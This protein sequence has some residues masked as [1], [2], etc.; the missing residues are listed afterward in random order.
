[1]IIFTNLLLIAGFLFLG[2]RHFRLLPTKKFFWPA[3][4]LK[5]SMGVLVGLLYQYYYQGGDT[6]AF[7]DSAIALKNS[8]LSS[9]VNFADIFLRNNYESLPGFQYAWIPSAF[10]VK[11]LSFFAWLTGDNY[12]LTGLYFSVFSFF[13]LWTWVTVLVRLLPNYQLAML[14]GFFFPSLLFWSSG[15]LKEALV[16]PLLALLS[17]IFLKY[18]LGDRLSRN[19]LIAAI[20]I[21]VALAVL[22]Y[23]IAAIFLAL[24]LAVL[25][26]RRILPAKAKWYSEAITLVLILLVMGGLVSL[27]HPNLWP[28]RLATVIYQNYSAYL[29]ASNPGSTITFS[30]LSAQLSGLVISLPKAVIAGLF[31]PLTPLSGAPVSLLSVAE[32]W[33]LLLGLTVG[34]TQFSMPESRENRLLVFAGILFILVASGLIAL[35]TPNLGTL[36][37]YKTSYLLFLLPLLMPAIYKLYRKLVLAG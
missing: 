18:Y 27:L 20:L 19:S 10:Y 28:S 15:I 6:I 12:W 16:I 4:L 7:F 25:L 37:R 8:A 35:S 1:M 33:V 29:A 9:W 21:F 32:N 17:G 13:G 3:V 26:T 24:G 30:H 36:A 23:F 14:S 11:I 2:F 34:L 31:L 5:L 22:K